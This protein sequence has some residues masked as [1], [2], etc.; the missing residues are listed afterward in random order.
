MY[1]KYFLFIG[2]ISVSTLFAE[3]NH[4]I[5]TYNLLNYEDE[6]DREPYYQLIINEIQPDIIVCQEVNADNGFNH[7]LSDVLNIAQ[8]NEWM[9]A[10]FTNQ[11]ASQDIALYYK[12]EHFSF[13]STAIINTAQSSGTRDVVE[14]VMEHLES[15]VQFRVYG[16]HLKASS[17]DTNAQQ[18]LEETT[19]LRN[20][21]NNLSSGAHFIV[22]GDFNIYNSEAI[23]DDYPY[24][25]E[26]AFDMLT[27]LGSDIDGQL[28]DPIDR[29]GEWHAPTSETGSECEFADVHTQSP[30]TT[31][32]GGG[33][34]GG[35]DD[36]FDWIF[37]SSSVMEDTYEMTYVENSYTAFGNDGQHCNQA[38][39]SGTNSA[40][41]QEIADALH[42]ASDHLPVFADFQFPSGD[43]SDYHVVIS[44]VMP[45]PSA[46]SDSY[47][48]WF[49]IIN[50]DSIPIDL[51]G[52]TI[53]DEGGDSHVIS[54]SAE[55]HPGEYMVLGR[56]SDESVNGGY[57][58]DY[59]YSSFAL[60]NSDDEIILLDQDEK[61]VDAV[62]YGAT[63]PYSSGISMYLIDHTSD[64]NIDSNWIASSMPYGD[65]DLGTPGRA[66]NDSIIVS[67]TN[68]YLLPNAF[69][70]YPPY[71]NPFNPTTQISFLINHTTVVSLNIYDMNGRLVQNIYRAKTT[72]GYYQSIW[73]AKNV[74]SGIYFLSLESE[75]KIITHKL[76]LMK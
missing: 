50:M 59:T 32:F 72:P 28:F 48:E 74:P 52:W 36:R 31:Q 58:S 43:E 30:R 53:M 6:N 42:G 61:M 68:D 20:Y 73:E 8:P 37:A 66:W 10:E 15:G 29:I 26:P 21:L 19:I 71:P 65:G 45:N 1:L 23:D 9:G 2:Y 7:F 55:I 11:S 40:V 64:N 62:S 60:A 34:N 12:P 67:T 70:L 16:V 38:I 47:G 56:N 44:E 39:N 5:L 3:S 4:T 69:E 24:Y 35:M 25:H 14:W 13:I 17:G 27:G 41:S 57:V 51:N 76:M 63:F 33:A 54:L 75:Q 49:E 18:R 46:A 22:C